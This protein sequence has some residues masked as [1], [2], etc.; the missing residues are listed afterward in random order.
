[1]SRVNNVLG[2]LVFIGL[3]GCASYQDLQAP[4][5]IRSLS[6]LDCAVEK[7]QCHYIA[8]VEV[9]AYFDAC[10]IAIAK[11]FAGSAPNPA[12]LAEMNAWLD[13]WKDLDTPALKSTVLDKNNPLRVYLKDITIKYLASVPADDVGIECS[14]LGMVKDGEL[15]VSMS[16]LLRATKGY[17]KAEKTSLQ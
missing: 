10:P 5:E 7:A 6:T 8:A 11:K 15:A 13:N 1:M 9:A 2:A 14:R 3:A 16:D 4:K 12:E 17:G